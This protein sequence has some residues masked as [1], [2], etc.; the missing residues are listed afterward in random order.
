M[1]NEQEGYSMK[2][3]ITSAK[4]MRIKVKSLKK[5]QK[6]QSSGSLENL[7]KFFIKDYGE[8]HLLDD[9]KL[10]L[11]Q[12]F[13]KSVN[14][15]LP[16]SNSIECH[17]TILSSGYIGLFNLYNF[18]GKKNR[19]L[20]RVLVD[21]SGNVT[22]KIDLMDHNL[23]EKDYAKMFHKLNKQLGQK[24]SLKNGL[25]YNIAKTQYSQSGLSIDL[26]FDTGKTV[27]NW[28]N[29]SGYTFVKQTGKVM[30]SLTFTFNL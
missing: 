12:A 27:R 17:L 4:Q 14:Q 2:N 9:L 7:L 26:N 11:N 18:D 22:L 19:L 24:Q 21:P 8:N 25:T 1:K 3:Q 13:Y 29:S 15:D 5:L 16:I 23:K 28:L 10:N 30:K 20:A 6:R